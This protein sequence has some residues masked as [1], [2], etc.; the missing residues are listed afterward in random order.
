MSEDLIHLKNNVSYAFNTRLHTQTQETSL[1]KHM[2]YR[3]LC[4]SYNVTSDGICATRTE[5][6][7][8]PIR[9]SA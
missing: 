2:V 6:G 4:C 1:Q 3:S 8:R 9:A 7:T 5:D